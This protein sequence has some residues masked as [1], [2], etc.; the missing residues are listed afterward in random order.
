MDEFD[1]YK[2]SAYSGGGAPL[3]RGYS[4]PGLTVSEIEDEDLDLPT[5]ASSGE[6][7]KEV[8]GNLENM[9]NRFK[10][11]NLG[12]SL[13]VP[14]D[15]NHLSVGQWVS[16]H[17]RAVSPGPGPRERG[18]FLRCNSNPNPS[19]LPISPGAISPGALSPGMPPG[20]ISPGAISPNVPRRPMSVSPI[21]RQFS[22]GSDSP[23]TPSPPHSLHSARIRHRMG[24]LQAERMKRRTSSGHA[25]RQSSLVR[26]DIT[27]FRTLHHSMDSGR[28]REQ[29]K[30][31]QGDYGQV[32]RVRSFITTHK[33]IIN[34]GDSYRLRSFASNCSLESTA[35]SP[36]GYKRAFSLASHGSYST[37]SS[38]ENPEGPT[39][40]V[41]VMGSG[42]SGKTTL[43]Q[44]FMTSE[45]L[46]NMEHSI[47]KLVFFIRV[48]SH[49]PEFLIRMRTRN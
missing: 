48:L 31:Q 42:G 44:Q 39:Y 41:L 5:A 29:Q 21:P 11:L 18:M 3:Q 22:Q 16:A 38:M 35:S 12:D 23:C 25:H 6:V 7:P 13:D 34:R 26:P 32:Y 45:Y 36:G 4:F 37:G 8:G 33:G 2:A 10:T 43:I 40:R 14:Y 30:Q 17:E 24:G 20:M 15:S 46:G 1:Q 28:D 27:Q 47:G 19:T 9:Q 49:R